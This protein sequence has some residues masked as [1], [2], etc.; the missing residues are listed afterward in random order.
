M[1]K[2]YTRACNFYYGINA[3][4][5]VK[6]KLALP[7][8]GNKNIAF[9][10]LEIITR[11]NNKILSK[12][13]NIKK[14]ATLSASSKKKVKQDLKKIVFK[15]KNFLKNI[16]FLEPSIMG[17]LNLTPD[18]FSDGGKFHNQKKAENHIFDMIKAGAKIIDVGGESTRPGS[19]TIK[20]IKNNKNNKKQ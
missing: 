17:I 8:C 4:L 12:I 11:K 5:L 2:Y 16:N 20:K 3:K 6:K 19:K 13:I 15:R 14:I 7:L 9:D 10:K 1:T 18:S